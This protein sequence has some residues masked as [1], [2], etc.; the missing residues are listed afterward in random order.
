MTSP[1]ED[2]IDALAALQ[3]RL[4]DTLAGFDE[5]QSTAEP[6]ITG[7]VA[8][9]VSA[10]TLHELAIAERLRALGSEP[11]P[12]GSFFSAIQ[13]LVVKTRAAFTDI[14]SGI[15]SAVVDGEKSLIGLYNDALA[16]ATVPADRMMLAQQKAEIESLMGKANQMA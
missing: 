14:D 16:T 3:V 11:D 15:L 1:T 7:I 6:E 12:D 2:Y 4:V 9:F 5:I 10:H 8:E 13:R